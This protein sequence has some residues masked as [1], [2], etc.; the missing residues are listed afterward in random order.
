MSRKSGNRFSEKAMRENRGPSSSPERLAEE[1][2]AF[3]AV[4]PGMIHRLGDADARSDGDLD[5][6][7]ARKE[8]ERRLVERESVVL[9]GDAERLAQ[10]SRARAQQ[11]LVGDAAPAAHGG[12]AMR[13]RERADQHRAGDARRLADEIEAPMDA[14]GAVDIGIAG[15]AEHDGIARGRPAKRVRRRIGVVIGLD[16]DDDAADAIEQERRTDQLGRDRVHAAGEEGSA[17]QPC[18]RTSRLETAGPSTMRPCEY[19]SL[20]RRAPSAGGWCRCCCAPGMRSP[21][22]PARPT[23]PRSSSGQGSRQP[24][25]TCSTRRRWPTRFAPPEP[26]VVIHQ[27]TD[28]PREFDEARMAASYASNAR[29]RTEGTRNLIAAAQAASRAPLHRAEH[30]LCLC[31]R[32]RAASRDRSAQSRRSGARGDREGRGR[33]GA[34]GSR[35]RPAST[36]SCCAMA[37]FTDR[38]PGTE[39]PGRKPALHVDAAAQAALLAVTRG[40][41]GIYNIADDDGAVSIDKARAALG[42]DPQFRLLNRR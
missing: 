35:L 40:A 14:V 32:R 15:R 19:S 26:E 7:R 39:T 37:C 33:H 10:P 36:R 2:R 13:R 34:A 4:A 17:E 11:P 5:V 3:E 1:A 12:E 24:S 29:I 6:V 27:L 41:P 25:S 28:L 31:A 22:P 8:L 30:R 42:F 9:V 16:L 21:A 18:H 38:A 20:A 23:M